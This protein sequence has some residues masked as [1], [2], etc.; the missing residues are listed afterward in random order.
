[1]VAHAPDSVLLRPFIGDGEYAA[2]A[3]DGAMEIGFKY[4]DL[5]RVRQKLLKYADGFQI[6][7][8]VR[9]RDGE[10]IAHAA[11]RFFIQRMHAVMI[12][13]KHGFVAHRFDFAHIADRAR[14]RSRERSQE[15][16]NS[17]G[18][19]AHGHIFPGKARIAAAV[20]KDAVFGAH[21]LYAPLR[22]RAVS[23]HLP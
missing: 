6:G 5:A 9:G 19:I 16:G 7:A 8:V 1:M 17:F 13:G 10:I 18:V 3:W 23:R 20:G 11:Q 12:A 14:F 15:H 22:Q 2:L 21:A 4:A